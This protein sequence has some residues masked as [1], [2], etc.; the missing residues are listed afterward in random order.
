MVKFV[1]VQG[2]EKVVSFDVSRIL[3]CNLPTVYAVASL[4]LR[5]AR[6]DSADT[7][8]SDRTQSAGRV[9]LFAGASFE[10]TAP[11]CETVLLS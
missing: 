7:Q 6:G 11:C 9:T 3:D 10:S 1:Q 4:H 5:C 2:Y 8:F